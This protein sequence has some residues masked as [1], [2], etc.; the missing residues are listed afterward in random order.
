LSQRGISDAQSDAFL[1]PD[2]DAHTHDPFLLK[3]MQKT[4]DR[5]CTAITHEEKILVYSDFDADGIPGAALMHDFFT[6]MGYPHV[7]FIAPDRHIYGFGFHPVIVKPYIDSGVSLIL[8]IDCGIADAS[9][10]AEIMEYA[11]QTYLRGVDI[12]ITD[13]HLPHEHLPEVYAIINP[14]Q[15]DCLYPEKMLCGAAVIYKLIVA[16]MKTIQRADHMHHTQYAPRIPQGYDKWLLDLVGIS[17]LSDMVPLTGENRTLAHFGLVV[18]RKSKRPGIHMLCHTN[19]IQKPR[20]VEEDVT[21]TM[22]PRINVASRLASP[23]LAFAL[24]TTS[25][26]DQAES[27]AKELNNINTKRKTLVSNTMTKVQHILQTHDIRSS[28][29][30]VVGSL[31]F[32]PPILGLVATQLIKVHKKPVF[33]WG[34]S[35]EGVIKGSVRSI[36]SVDIVE[37]MNRAEDGVF[38]NRGGHAQSGGFSLSKEQLSKLEPTLCAAYTDIYG[39]YIPAEQSHSDYVVDLEITGDDVGHDIYAQI[40]KLAPYGVGNEKPVCAIR[41]IHILSVRTFGKKKEHLEIDCGSFKA[42]QFFTEYNQ[43]QIAQIEQL[44]NPVIIGYIELNQF[45]GAREIRVKLVDIV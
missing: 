1:Y 25:D 4:V 3:D 12:V 6:M 41:D 30:L 22:A 28:P 26:V 7:E 45:L 23:A 13:H 15:T 20:L 33:V 39:D 16:C 24:L 44:S 5:I 19:M 43:E 34:Q 17:T 9:Q 2:F 38:I 14:K 42:I 32:K 27:L 21:F 11:Q 37:L 18:L 40:Q 8:T 10:S 36:P 35:D 31:D 29:I